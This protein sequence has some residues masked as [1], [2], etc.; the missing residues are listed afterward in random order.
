MSD[1]CGNVVVTEGCPVEGVPTRPCV[2]VSQPT[3]CATVAIPRLGVRLAVSR[4]GATR[5]DR[6]V[7]PQLPVLYLVADAGEFIVDESGRFLIAG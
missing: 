6:T 4:V 3:P 1:P 2:T 7:P 5:T